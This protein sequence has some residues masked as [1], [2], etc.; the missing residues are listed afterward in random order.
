MET[1][2]IIKKYNI[3]EDEL[4][5]LRKFCEI[6]IDFKENPPPLLMREFPNYEFE[7][8]KIISLNF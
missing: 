6:I 4:N 8:T 1:K 7:K 3:S 2:R 5:S